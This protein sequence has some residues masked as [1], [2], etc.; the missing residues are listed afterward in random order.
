MTAAATGPGDEAL[1]TRAF[2]LPRKAT[3]RYGILVRNT[4]YDTAV[5]RA[6]FV[7]SVSSG[8]ASLAG[9]AV[10]RGGRAGLFQATHGSKRVARDG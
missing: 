7:D 6:V 9:A 10:P 3:F 1:W 5:T 4:G 2:P 8:R